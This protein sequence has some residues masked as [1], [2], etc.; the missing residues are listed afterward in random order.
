MSRGESLVGKVYN[1]LT[2]VKEVPRDE[3][4]RRRKWLCKCECGKEFTTFTRYL[5]RGSRG[6][7]GCGDFERMSKAMSKPI[8]VSLV[9]SLIST[10][11]SNARKRGHEYTLNKETFEKL[12]FTD[13]FYC[14]DKPS[15]VYTKTKLVGSIVVNGID[16]LD[17]S[18]GYTEDNS[19][20]CCTECNYMKKE[21]SLEKFLERIL[22]IAKLHK[23]NQCLVPKTNS[24]ARPVTEST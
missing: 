17:N 14:G 9:N 21:L 20:A 5:Q 19:V 16:R 4:S 10:Y 12:I 24:D 7:C 3:K 2:V 8:G 18:I 11:K 15:R 23:D 22:K 6:D 13:C 1:K